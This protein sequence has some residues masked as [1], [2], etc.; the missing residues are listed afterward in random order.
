[1]PKIHHMENIL[2]VVPKARLNP[3]ENAQKS[4]Y[5]NIIK[6]APTTGLTPMKNAQKSSYRKYYKGAPKSTANPFGKCP[7]I[8][9]SKI[10]QIW[11]QK[12]G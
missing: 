10:L 5:R 8:I 4:S 7:K 1:M 3:L 9:I 12:Q 2:K 11:H 6:L